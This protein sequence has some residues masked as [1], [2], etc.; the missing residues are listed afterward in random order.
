MPIKEFQGGTRT[1]FVAIRGQGDSSWAKGQP[2]E[3]VPE[4]VECFKLIPSCTTWYKTCVFPQFLTLISFI[5]FVWLVTDT[6]QANILPHL[7]K[8]NFSLCGMI[9]ICMFLSITYL[10]YQ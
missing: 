1:H 3:C 8:F 5:T 4:S 7:S 9:G 6:L 10:V 2:V